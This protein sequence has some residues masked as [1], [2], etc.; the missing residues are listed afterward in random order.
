[1]ARSHAKTAGLDATSSMVRDVV[2]HGSL[3]RSQR[4]N[5]EPADFLSHPQMTRQSN[6]IY[7]PRF[8]HP[9]RGHGCRPASQD[10]SPSGF[11]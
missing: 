3:R 10:A 4:C 9:R 11:G 5:G 6:A 1:M 2:G 8:P 7:L